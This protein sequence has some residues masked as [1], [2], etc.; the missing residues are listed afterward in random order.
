MSYKDFKSYKW[1]VIIY[2]F[3]VNF[4]KKYKS[5]FSNWIFKNSN[6]IIQNTRSGQK[7]TAKTSIKKASKKNKIKLL[8]FARISLNKLLEDY[9]DFLRNKGFN[10]WS[11][12]TPKTSLFY[13]IKHKS[14]WTSTYNSYLTSIKK[15]ANLKICLISQVNYFADQKI[16]VL[17][18]NL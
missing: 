7:N 18:E 6:Q 13:K 16:S 1:S 5:N 10:F 12:N 4:V 9:K 17:K 3:K 11:K 2:D 15:G 14:K 8:G